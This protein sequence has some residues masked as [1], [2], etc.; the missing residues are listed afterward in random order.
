MYP[1]TY[2]I[3]EEIQERGG[4][5][6]EVWGYLFDA[7]RRRLLSILFLVFVFP[8]RYNFDYDKNVV[9]YRSYPIAALP[10]TSSLPD[11]VPNRSLGLGLIHSLPWPDW[12]TNPNK[13]NCAHLPYPYY[14]RRWNVHL[15]PT[16]FPFG[17]QLCHICVTF[18]HCYVHL[19]NDGTGSMEIL[20]S[21]PWDSVLIIFYFSFL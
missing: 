19:P 8:K 5:H 6:I 4:V 3:I 10:S 21:L 18:S 9:I 17:Q 7:G 16:P 15:F 14:W 13:G 20:I 11:A 12:I 1:I 2:F